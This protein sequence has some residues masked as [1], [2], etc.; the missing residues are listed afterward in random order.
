MEDPF[1]AVRD[2]PEEEWE[3]VSKHALGTM[4]TE[5]P[6]SSNAKVGVESLR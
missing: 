5:D 4:F 2:D 1:E 3:I 6:E